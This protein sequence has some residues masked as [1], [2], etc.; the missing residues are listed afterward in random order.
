MMRF[1]QTLFAGSTAAGFVLAAGVALCSANAVGNQ[2]VTR[3]ASGQSTATAVV[4]ADP[5]RAATGKLT[6]AKAYATASGQG[7]GIF[8][9][10]GLAQAIATFTQ[11]SNFHGDLKGVGEGIAQATASGKAQRQVRAFPYHATAIATLEAEG[12]TYQLGQPGPARATAT[13][14]GTTFMLGYGEIYPQASMAGTCLKQAGGAGVGVGRSSGEALAFYLL[15]AL[16]NAQATATMKGDAAVTRNGIRYFEGL[17]DAESTAQ[18]QI[19][20]LMIYQAQTLTG[21]ATLEGRAVY[22]I[23]AHGHAIGTATGWADGIA[24]TTSAVP[25]RAQ[26]TA[27]GSDQAKVNYSGSGIADAKA[28]MVLP[29]PV[30]INTKVYGQT[31]LATASWE[32]HPKLTVAASSSFTGLAT[33][34]ASGVRNQF[35]QS[36][37]LA[38]AAMT[39]SN[40]NIGVRGAYLL[41]QATAS[42]DGVKMFMATGTAV[43]TATAKGFNQI[44]DLVRAPA[45]RT[46][47]VEVTPRLLTLEA[48]LRLLT[49]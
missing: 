25:D 9:R 13:L 6:S 30:I 26:V 3:Y 34:Q 39:V 27:I 15:G 42:C 43:A 40:V 47:V 36:T 12:F 48:Q 4:S 14:Y 41:A 31:A 22:T 28:K 5:R 38:T 35:A 10:S 7:A 11:G 37:G 46:V 8:I 44:N 33:L 45:D 21:Q 20:T 2:E 18:V 19:T 32:N 17:G 24:A 16:G 23:G 29:N 49:V 1:G